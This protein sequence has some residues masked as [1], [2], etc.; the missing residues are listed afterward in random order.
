MQ[1]Q[2]QYARVLQHLDALC[3]G[4]RDAIAVMATVAGE[5]YHAFDR[6]N[7]VGFYRN[8]GGRVLK[9]GPYQGGHG[10]L[11]IPFDRG[12]CGK[13]ARER[14]PQNVPD[15]MAVPYHIACASTTRSEL[16]V[17]IVNRAGELLGVLDIDSDAPA[18]FDS[19]DEQHIQEINRYFRDIPLES[20]KP[21]TQ[22]RPSKP[23]PAPGDSRSLRA[24]LL[25]ALALIAPDVRAAAELVPSPEPGWPQW[26]GPRRDGICTETGLMPAWPEGGPPLAWQVQ[27]MGRGY[28][29]PIIAQ[30]RIYL[31]GDIGNELHVFALDLDGRQLWQSRNGRAWTGQYPGARACV[32]FSA[33]RLFHLN[34]HGRL[35]CL[36]AATG[37]E[38]WAKET[39]EEY[40][41]RVPTWA[42][43]E[44]LL[45]DRSRLIATP[46]G[47]TALMVAL[48]TRTGAEIWRAEPLRLA[49]AEASTQDRL[50][51][52]AGEVDN[53]GYASPLLLEF[54]GKRLI[55][56]C[57]LR[58]A[59]A[60][61][62]DTGRL[63]WTQPLPTRHS[64][65]AA[66]PVLVGDAVFITAPDTDAGGLFALRRA[67]TMVGV[68]RRWGALLDTCHGGA[69][70][71][72]D[73]LYGSWYRRGKGWAAIDVHTGQVAGQWPNLAPGAVLYADGRLYC[74]A[75]DGEMALLEPTATGATNAGQFRLVPT[76]VSDAWA[77]PVILDG[78]LYLRYHE[79]LWCYSVRARSATDRPRRTPP[80]A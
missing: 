30:D 7:W 55:V 3:A 2:D 8:V 74:L 79:S 37:R 18:A 49:A 1:K 17:P 41:G 78:R 14:L 13:C 44:C 69:V 21:N 15:V 47:T 23:R 5:L 45:V 56:S 62:A 61:D 25:L 35:A 42:L 51:G 53:A 26:R 27:G 24:G 77:H 31:T 57:S 4:E 12:V 70:L 52:R 68:E 60:V 20:P 43:S 64:V 9:I 59:F 28:S 6:F 65:V 33:G 73:R 34:A 11:T 72:R 40:G 71:V 16:V 50:A 10:C 46:G 19:V 58:H 75:Q 63:Q 32:V 29:C 66:T 80:A 67:G 54:E 38:L 48:D 22:P 36:D 76:R 39:L